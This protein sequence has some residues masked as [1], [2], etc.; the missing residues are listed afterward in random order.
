MVVSEFAAQTKVCAVF[1]TVFTAFVQA[2][3][4]RYCLFFTSA[5]CK[6]FFV[7]AVVVRDYSG[8]AF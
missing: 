2:T 3:Q 6:S 1:N 7:V 4:F 5:L 8:E